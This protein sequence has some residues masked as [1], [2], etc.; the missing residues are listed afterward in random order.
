MQAKKFKGSNQ[1]IKLYNEKKKMTN[2]ESSYTLH[3]LHTKECAS[4]ANAILA[5][6]YYDQDDCE[7][8]EAIT[9]AK[10]F[11]NAFPEYCNR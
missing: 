6:K 11:K 8:M 5:I 7:V 2:D 10:S 1:I 3:I 4:I 9:W